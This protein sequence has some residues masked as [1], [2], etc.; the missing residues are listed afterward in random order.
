MY[1]QRHNYS[2]LESH[3]YYLSPPRAVLEVWPPRAPRS[4]LLAIKLS[5]VLWT[6][7]IHFRNEKESSEGKEKTAAGIEKKDVEAPHGVK[8]GLEEECDKEPGEA[9]DQDG[10]RDQLVPDLQ[11]EDLCRDDPDVAGDTHVEEDEVEDKEDERNPANS[12][13]AAIVVPKEV[14]GHTE[15]T[16]TDSRLAGQQHL[17]A[18]DRAGKHHGYNLEES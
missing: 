4:V 16:E 12:L 2:L 3:L 17:P 9:A 10:E 13:G 15:E 7:A 8:H 5:D 11:R 18:G 6:L 14:A 1:S